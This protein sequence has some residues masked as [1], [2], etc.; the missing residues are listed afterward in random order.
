M[1]TTVFEIR[2]Q[3]TNEISHEVKSDQTGSNLER[4]EDG[5]YR[6]VDFDRFY[7]T[8]RIEP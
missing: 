3:E 4:V 7:I 8:E 6:K 1:T 5:L 2:D